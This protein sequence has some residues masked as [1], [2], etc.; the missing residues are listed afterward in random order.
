MLKHDEHWKYGI[1]EPSQ[2]R[3]H[4]L[5]SISIKYPETIDYRDSNIKFNRQ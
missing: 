5:N 2:K 1:K 3:P 4:I